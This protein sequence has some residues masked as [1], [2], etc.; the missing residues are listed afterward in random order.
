MFCVCVSVLCSSF[1]NFQRCTILTISPIQLAE[2]LRRSEPPPPE[3]IDAIATAKVKCVED[4]ID[5]CHRLKQEVG[6]FA[7]M[8][9]SGFKTMDFLNCC[10]FAEGDSRILMSKLARDRLKSF[11][12]DS[13]AGSTDEIIICEQLVAGM[14]KAVAAGKSK[15]EAWDADWKAVYALAE[16]VMARILRDG[17]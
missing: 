1:K 5:L 14:G 13:K 11:S 7:L 15:Q 4:S 6:S 8:A 9:D 17:V 3:L 16:T 2:C 12:K 10:K